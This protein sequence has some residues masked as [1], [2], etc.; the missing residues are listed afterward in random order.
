LYEGDDP[1]MQRAYEQARA[2]FRYFWREVA[3]ERRRIVPALDLACV[4]APF[5]DGES[6]GRTDDNPEIQHMWMSEVNFDGRTVSGVLMNSPHRLKSI[7]EGDPVRVPLAQISDWMYVINDEVFGAYT[8]NL[9]RSRM[10]L[11]ER[12]QHDAA[13]GLNFGDPTKVRVVPEPKEGGGLL[14]GWFGENE[15][16]TGEHPM[17]VN[18]AE[19]LTEQIAED[20]SL[21]TAVNDRG[22]TLLH[23]EALAWSAPTVKVLLA[24][25]ADPNA[26]TND[27]LTPLQLAESL[28]WENVVGLLAR[29]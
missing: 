15:A 9:L 18:M 28:G 19:S 7:K 6:S 11:R 5:S 29:T 20:P 23:M 14:K 25:G 24:A 13:W 17:S 2:S 21:V 26:K 8:V 27:G 4:K 16:E 1:D 22:W 10:G 3:W 12:Q